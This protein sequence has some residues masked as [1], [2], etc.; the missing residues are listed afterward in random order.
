VQFPSQKPQCTAHVALWGPLLPGKLAT[1][2]SREPAGVAQWQC[3]GPGSGAP[4][5]IG[6]SLPYLARTNHV[7]QF[8]D[9]FGGHWTHP[10][11]VLLSEE[12]R[13]QRHHITTNYPPNSYPRSD[14]ATNRDIIRNRPTI[15][16]RL[17]C[18]NRKPRFLST[19]LFPADEPV[20]VVSWATIPDPSFATTPESV[21]IR[22][23]C[24]AST[25]STGKHRSRNS[26]SPRRQPTLVLLAISF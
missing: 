10:S 15:S 16:L 20:V 13:R 18:R 24:T 11:P 26:R 12:P 5:L 14:P 6:P 25:D 22:E 23:S 21:P 8:S 7:G 4:P 2:R 3:A 1:E 9:L 17:F 19:T